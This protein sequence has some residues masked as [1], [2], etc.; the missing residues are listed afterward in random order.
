MSDI[1]TFLDQH[2]IPY[3]KFDHPAIFTVAEAQEKA[4]A[5]PGGHIKNL[6]LR[7]RKGNKHYLV[8]IPADKQLN[9]KNLEALLD[10]K[11]GFASPERLQ[12]YLGV[13]PGSVT[14]LGLINDQKHEVAVILDT[15]LSTY[16]TLSCHPLINTATLVIP[17]EGIEEFLKLRGN[18]VRYL[19][20]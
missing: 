19:P 18:E 1:Y 3:Q 4:S 10:E 5:I 15:E 12:Q 16:D 20:L 9:L 7:N 13:T 8:V 11:L 6:F 2:K 14:I 17:R